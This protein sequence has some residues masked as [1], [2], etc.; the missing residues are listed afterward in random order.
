VGPLRAGVL[1]SGAPVIVKLGGS[2]VTRKRGEPRLRPKIL[3]RLA[4]ELAEPGNPP[5]VVLHGAG[6]F[7]HPGALRWKLAEPPGSEPGAPARRVRGAAIV[8]ARVRRL[9][10]AVLRALLD[11]GANPWSVPPASVAWNRAGS[12]T[13][14]DAGPFRTALDR[15]AVPVAF[16]DVVPDRAWGFSILSADTLA[17]ELAR[18]LAARR[19]LFVSDVDGILESATEADGRRAT[20]VVPRVTSDTVADLGR[21]AGAA[22]ATGGIRAKARGMIAIGET[23]VDAGLIS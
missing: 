18:R 10:G 5:T 13:E 23:G 22:D 14:L 6:S 8:S 21:R 16:G 11:A 4:E 17:V 15:G 19:V 9:H 7:G 20:R 3:R 1:A 2:V 12:L